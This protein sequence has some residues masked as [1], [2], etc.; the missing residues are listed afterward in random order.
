MRKLNI[1]LSIALA[2]AV[3]MLLGIVM[4]AI[5]VYFFPDLIVG[6]APP[7]SR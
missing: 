7:A 4:I 5:L 3:A 6:I 2:V 1:V